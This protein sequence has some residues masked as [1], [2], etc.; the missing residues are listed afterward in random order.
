MPPE[1]HRH[2]LHEP[3]EEAAAESSSGNVAAPDEPETGWANVVEDEVGE[4]VAAVNVGDT[5]VCLHLLSGGGL[6]SM[7]KNGYS[8]PYVR[9]TLQGSSEKAKLSTV[10]YKTLDPEWTEEI[11]VPI[12]KS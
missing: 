8:D 6:M 7:D 3:L 4:E 11:V 9:V 12:P 5:F 1:H 2:H 10:K